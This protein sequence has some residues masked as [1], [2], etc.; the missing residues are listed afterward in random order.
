M[1]RLDLASLV[2]D[3]PLKDFDTQ[4]LGKISERAHICAYVSLLGIKPASYDGTNTGAVVECVLIH[5][6]TFNPL[7]CEQSKGGGR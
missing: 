7:F 6:A 1:G 5:D 2:I 4:L 3:S